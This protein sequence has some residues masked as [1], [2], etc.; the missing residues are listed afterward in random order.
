MG[1]AGEVRETKRKAAPRETMEVI[2]TMELL[3]DEFKPTLAPLVW[4][5]KKKAYRLAAR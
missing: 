3:W 1:C 4:T 2:L 5:V